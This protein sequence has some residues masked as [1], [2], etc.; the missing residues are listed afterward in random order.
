MKE[1][2]EVSGTIISTQ[3]DVLDIE[4][5]ERVRKHGDLSFIGPHE[6]WGACGE[7]WEEVKA[8]VHANDLDQL[9][10]ELVDL[11]VAA[12]WGMVSLAEVD[13]DRSP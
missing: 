10:K 9:Y 1:R 11:A 5:R 6:I 8:A 4:L 3:L 7:E 2:R 12:L 13:S